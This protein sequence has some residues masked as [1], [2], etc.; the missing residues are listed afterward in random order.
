VGAAFIDLD[1]TLLRHASG[2]V[3]NAALG[4]QGVVDPERSLPGQGVLYRVYDRF[5]ENLV[6]MALPGGG[7][8]RQGLVPG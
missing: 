2:R 3:L 7:A 6:S 1:R 8:R 5:G 4:A